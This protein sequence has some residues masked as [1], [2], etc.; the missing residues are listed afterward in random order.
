M[1]ATRVSEQCYCAPVTLLT[2]LKRRR[3]TTS[4]ALPVSGI[5]LIKDSPAFLSEASG[6]ARKALIKAFVPE[7]RHAFSSLAVP[8]ADLDEW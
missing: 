7:D 2:G 4:T 1:W 3:A 6:V 8:H 5:A